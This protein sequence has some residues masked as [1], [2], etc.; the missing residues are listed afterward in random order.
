MGDDGVEAMGSEGYF[1]NEF[2]VTRTNE[3][4]DRWGGTYGTGCAFRWRSSRG[5]ARPSGATSSSSTGSTLD[6]V[7]GGST[8]P[9]A[10]QLKAIES[11]GAT[12][13]NTGI[14]WDEARVPTIA[15]ERPRAA[16]A[17]VTGS[18]KARSGFP[19]VR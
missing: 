16:F 13:L 8:W 18:R 14:G 19:F 1:I 7:P 12:I 5:C 17:W 4:T 9:E 15:D 11:A 6:L 2:L 10:V 3:R